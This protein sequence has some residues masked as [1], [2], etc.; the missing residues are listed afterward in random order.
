MKS[1]TR[2]KTFIFFI[3]GVIVALLVKVNMQ[4]GTETVSVA[5]SNS[6]QWLTDSLEKRME[7]RAA[8][9]KE[10]N[11]VKVS[12]IKNRM[13][14]AP[15]WSLV[16]RGPSRE[17]ILAGGAPEGED[18]FT[19]NEFAIRSDAGVSQIIMLSDHS[20]IS[21]IDS[22]VYPG[23]AN[24]DSTMLKHIDTLQDY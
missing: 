2:N 10:G 7:E 16:Y 20:Y 24:Y 1:T 21:S 17:I 5:D 3:L 18:F 12:T 9:L 6:Y 19:G 14:K 13:Q 23:S 22:V 8:R 15:R 4:T 11:P